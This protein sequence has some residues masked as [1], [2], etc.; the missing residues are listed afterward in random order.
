MTTVTIS[1]TKLEQMKTEIKT[2]RKSNIY[3]R[4]LEFEKNIATDK[5]LTRKDLGF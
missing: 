4:L 1:R 2:L 5:K 3:L